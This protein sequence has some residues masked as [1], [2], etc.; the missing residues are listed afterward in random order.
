[1]FW[2]KLIVIFILS[3]LAARFISVN[4]GVVSWLLLGFG[5]ATLSFSYMAIVPTW[6][7]IL[8]YKGNL[9][10]GGNL[11]YNFGQIVVIVLS[12]GVLVSAYLAISEGLIVAPN[13]DIRGTGSDKYML[14]WFADKTDQLLPQVGMISLPLYAY[15]I[16]MLLWSTWFAYTLVGWLKLAWHKFSTPLIWQSSGGE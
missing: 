6:L 15:R 10:K 4:V 13:M 14:Q 9:F 3:V 5:F 1:M 12:V 7:V 8:N 11:R 2:P 16:L